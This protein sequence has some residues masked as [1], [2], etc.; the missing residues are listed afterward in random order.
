MQHCPRIARFWLCALSGFESLRTHHVSTQRPHA[1]PTP[2]RTRTSHFNRSAA[3]YPFAG[4][5]SSRTQ[6]SPLRP[7]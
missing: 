7:R 3:F 5:V 6:F 2:H 1:S 4:T